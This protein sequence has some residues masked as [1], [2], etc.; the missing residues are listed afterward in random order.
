MNTETA[1]EEKYRKY[2]LDLKQKSIDNSCKTYKAIP[3]WRDAAKKLKEKH[4]YSTSDHPIDIKT[5]QPTPESDILI[6]NTL[7]KSIK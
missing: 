1:G 2:L 4:M 3:T 5:L 6:C 7:P